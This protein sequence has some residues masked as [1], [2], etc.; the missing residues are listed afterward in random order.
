MQQGLL[1]VA[2]DLGAQAADVDVDDVG[3]GIEVVVPHVFQEH[4]AGDDLSGVAHQVLEQPELPGLQ[5]DLPA[6]AGDGAGQQIHLQVGDFQPGLRR[7]SATAPEQGLEAGV[8]LR[9]GEG[10]DQ[11]VVAARAQALDPVVHLAQGAEDQHRRAIPGGSQ[12]A[13]D[14][15]PVQLRQHAV[16]D[17]HV[18]VG[19]RGHEQS[20][21]A[22]TGVIDDRPRL[23]QGLAE[24]ADHLVV[25]FDQ[26]HAHGSRGR[27]GTSLQVRCGS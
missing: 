18:I 22:V 15:E 24:V 20:L 13:H 2:V 14:G 11:V 1:E 23:T 7:F 21:P 8:E 9:E 25:I 6:G 27:S 26:E 5:L 17:Q 10:L 19:A 16:D 3:L 12:G 4:G